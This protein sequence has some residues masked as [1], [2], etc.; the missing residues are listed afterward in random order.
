MRSDP[1]GGRQWCKL[2]AKRSFCEK[3]G[4]GRL[5]YYPRIETSQN[6]TGFAQLAALFR[7]TRGKR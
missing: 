1:D 2:F 3:A 6:E 5:G 7:P 4:E